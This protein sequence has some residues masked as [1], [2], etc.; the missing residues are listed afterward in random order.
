MKISEMNN[1]QACEAITRLAGPLAAICEDEEVKAILD[2]IE[3]MSKNGDS[4]LNVFTKVLPRLVAF[5]LK[6]HKDDVY[7]II[8]ALTLEPTG[9]IGKMNFIQTV[10]VVKDSWDEVI[11][12]FFTSSAKAAK[13][14]TEE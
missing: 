2:E 12:G 13:K 8:G 14:N 10:N 4:V 6:T 3:Q 1:D 7:E 9:K 11:A 5:G